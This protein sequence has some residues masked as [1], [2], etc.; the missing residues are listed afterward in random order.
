MC[1]RL[2]GLL[3]AIALLSFAVVG[4]ADNISFDT[5]PHSY[6]GTAAQLGYPSGYA[7]RLTD[8]TTLGTDDNPPAG[9]VWGANPVD[10]ASGFTLSFEFRM[11]GGW[12]INT[13]DPAGG[14]AG[15]DGFAFVIQN[16]PQGNQAIGR[17]AGGLGY[18]YIH[19]SLAVEFDA[20]MNAG[21]YGDPDGNHV[22]VN[23]SANVVGNLNV[24]HHDC[25]N[26]E[27]TAPGYPT[28]FP[29]VGCT[30]DPG[31]IVVPVSRPLNDGLIQ[32][33]EIV[34]SQNILS[35][36]LNSDRMFSIPVDLST[37]LDL[38][39]GTD[40]YIGF[41]AGDRNA[42][43]NHDIL[44]ASVPEPTTIFLFSTG[45]AFLLLRRRRIM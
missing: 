43:Q 4:L 13:P 40:A 7:V 45:L 27:L 20:F 21:W 15:G 29:G 14:P 33:A 18:M 12:D 1:W 41:T 26:G 19:N 38:Q 37:L 32:M 11:S 44:F 22:A 35:L 42:F 36:Y 5:L 23:A 8:N 28:D 31:L 17:G 39:R 3:V 2:K 6:V 34:Y 9:A 30:S 24:P 16:D 25:T 10:V